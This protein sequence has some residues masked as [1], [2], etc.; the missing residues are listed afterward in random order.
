MRPVLTLSTQGQLDIFLSCYL[1]KRLLKESQELEVTPSEQ[2]SQELDDL[3][4]AARRSRFR[5][6]QEAQDVLPPFCLVGDRNLPELLEHLA[7]SLPEVLLAQLVMG[8]EES[9]LVA[10]QLPTLWPVPSDSR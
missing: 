8:H 4:V 6:P 3:M 7:L 9:P 1:S 5:C 10:M 2:E